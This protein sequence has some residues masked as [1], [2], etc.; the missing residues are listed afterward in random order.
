M[1]P[2]EYERRLKKL[3]PNADMEIVWFIANW[4]PEGVIEQ[5]RLSLKGPVLDI[6]IGELRMIL[7]SDDPDRKHVRK[8][9][10][11]IRQILEGGD[12][13]LPGAA[14]VGCGCLHT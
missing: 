11:E 14:A 1:Q 8:L 6:S 7:A 9:F 13:V 12:V 10:E 2:D 5:G 4:D 3:A